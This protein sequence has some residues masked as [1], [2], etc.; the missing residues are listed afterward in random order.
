MVSADSG[1]PEEIASVPLSGKTVRLKVETQF[2]A[3]PEIARF[4][5]SLDG[6]A[7]LPL[8]L[9]SSCCPIPLGV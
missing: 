3:A 2:Q 8:T 4:S 7:W 5:Y 6:I 9:P 1:H